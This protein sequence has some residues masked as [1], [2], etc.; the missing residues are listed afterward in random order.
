MLFR[1]Y[2]YYQK[3]NTG[4]FLPVEDPQTGELTLSSHYKKVLSK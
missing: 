3:E 2:A 4:H 1:K